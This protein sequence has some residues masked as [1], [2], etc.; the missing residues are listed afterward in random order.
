VPTGLAP[1]VDQPEHVVDVD[2]DLLDQLDLEDEV[3]V[4]RLLLGCVT[5]A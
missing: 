3:V 2:L 5:S 1:P 4:D